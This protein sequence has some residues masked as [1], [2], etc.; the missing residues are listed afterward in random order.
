MKVMFWSL[1]HGQ[2]GVTS[3]LAATALRLALSYDRRILML[4]NQMTH[5]MLEA[6]FGLDQLEID[7]NKGIDPVYNALRNQNI[8]AQEISSHSVSLL[9]SGNLEMLTGTNHDA[10]SIPQE[11]GSLF[12]GVIDL[13]AKAYDMVL[14]DTHTGIDEETAMLMDRVDRIVVCVNQNRRVMESTLEH[15]ERHLSHQ[16]K[17]VYLIG[18]YDGQSKMT[19]RNI[20]R[21]YGIKEVITM[22]YVSAYRDALNSSD[23]IDYI[24]RN[25]DCVQE[26]DNFALMESLMEL[27]RNLAGDA[28]GKV[29]DW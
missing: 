9:N 23:L 25:I 21:R 3:A 6:Y 27:C 13:A 20:M 1:Y 17:V 8:T 26:D 7:R 18:N 16:K 12:R 4:H 19:K 11:A 10:K 14:I 22:P 28:V 15:L 5:N 2:T 24:H 29:V